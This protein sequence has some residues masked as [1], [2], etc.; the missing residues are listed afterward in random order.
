MRIA[1]INIDW[2][3]KSNNIKKEIHSEINKLDLDFLIVNE[4]IESFSFDDNYFTYHSVSIPI[5]EEFQYLNYGTYLN[6]QIPIR[7]TI[8]SKYKSIDEIATND[9][10]TSICHKFNI[11][12]KQICIYGSIIGTWGIKYQNGIAKIELENFKVD[13]NNIVLNN[14]NVIIA[15][16]FNTSFFDTEKRQLSTIN[17]RKELLNFTNKLKIYRATENIKNCID[18]IFISNNLLGYSTLKIS[19]F[20]DNDILKD[21]PHKGILL[22]LSF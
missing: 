12:N 15:G 6:G 4:N 8:F 7:T 22:E 16:D 3:K 5:E 21:N 18:H 19:T 2:L 1:V 17:S 10:H 9:S 20:L 11:D 14:E 13:V